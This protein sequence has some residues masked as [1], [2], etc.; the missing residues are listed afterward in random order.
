[1][2]QRIFD[3]L[4]RQK[5]VWFTL[6]I[7]S[8]FILFF[9]REIGYG[10]NLSQI[11]SSILR[12][13]SLSFIF[14]AISILLLDYLKGDR[15]LAKE[16]ESDFVR[17]NLYLNEELRYLVKELQSTILSTNDNINNKNES[18][19]IVTLTE[20]DKE[21]LFDIIT[22]TVSQNINSEFL[23]SLDEK[24][25]LKIIGESRY[26]ELLINFEQTRNRILKEIDSLSRRANLNLVIGSV[27]TILA[28]GVLFTSVYS[29]DVSFTDTAKTLSYFIPRVT[30][31][32][33]IEVFSFFFLKLYRSNLND[34]KYYQNEMT[35]IEFK[36]LSLK[37]ALMTED[38]ETLREIIS[39]T[40]KIERNFILQKGETTVEIETSKNQNK[41]DKS[42][43][44]N[45]NSLTE[46]I[47]KLRGKE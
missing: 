22:K 13:Y 1:M 20:Y 40:N 32:I 25:S 8:T 28:V 15:Y 17:R 33:F 11:G 30:T 14:L 43:T 10:F 4:K 37:S 44:D 18:N 6:A 38:K 27:T 35:N 45:L 19:K 3:V 39:T 23:K 42:F 24:Y 31:V 12:V 2:Y 7:L 9:E 5:G 46:T 34:V 26:K 16:S 47:S 36:I 29:K 21:K 41:F